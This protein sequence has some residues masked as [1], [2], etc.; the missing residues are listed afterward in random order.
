M[1]LGKLV[2]QL[3]LDYTGVISGFWVAGGALAAAPSAIWLLPR[4]N[5]GNCD[6]HR[7]ALV[8]REDDRANVVRDGFETCGRS[9][10]R[11]LKRFASWVVRSAK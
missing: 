7:E 4:K 10:R 2:I 3:K 8:R 11:V 1:E 9:P 5:P 6:R